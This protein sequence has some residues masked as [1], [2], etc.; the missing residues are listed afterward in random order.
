MIHEFLRGH[1]CRKSLFGESC[2]GVCT[3]GCCFR[4]GT[5]LLLSLSDSLSDVCASFLS[6][7]TLPKSKAVPGVFGALV[8]EGP[9][10]AKAPVPRPNAEE[11]VAVVG[12]ETAEFEI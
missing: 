4:T 10:D 3:P 11:A 6:L 7:P 5:F 9:K 1:G 12:E 2:T 8:T